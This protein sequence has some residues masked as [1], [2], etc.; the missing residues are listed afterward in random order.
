MPI[1]GYASTG[2]TREISHRGVF[3]VRIRK[4]YMLA[5]DMI[6]AVK[7]S[8]NKHTKKDLFFALF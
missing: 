5:Y 8:Y 3:G 1:A 6:F 2:S 7:H 4:S